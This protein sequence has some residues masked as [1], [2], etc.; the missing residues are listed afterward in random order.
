MTKKLAIVADPADI[1]IQDS[2]SAFT[3]TS[4]PDLVWNF[5]PTAPSQLE[6]RLKTDCPRALMIGT[7]YAESCRLAVQYCIDRQ[8]RC[9]VI[10]TGIEDKSLIAWL[11]EQEIEVWE[12]GLLTSFRGALAAAISSSKRKASQSLSDNPRDNPPPIK[13]DGSNNWLERSAEVFN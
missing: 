13:C 7:K 12:Y 4:Q 11:T 3:Q 1:R 6:Q 9:S 8:L 2:L 10:N 5:L